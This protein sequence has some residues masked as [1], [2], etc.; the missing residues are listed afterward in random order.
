MQS[1]T[2]FS[3]ELLN[4]NTLKNLELDQLQSI[5]ASARESVSVRR[6]G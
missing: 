2:N 6:A 1:L 3:M 4:W 5:I